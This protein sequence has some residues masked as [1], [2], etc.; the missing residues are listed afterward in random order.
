MLKNSRAVGTIDVSRLAAA[1]RGPGIDSR[2]WVSLAIV[3]A[4]K[5]D[6]DE[7]VFVDVTL[8]PSRRPEVARVGQEYAGPGFGLHTPLQVD[9]EVLV[10]APDG[11]PDNGLVVTR[12][13]HSASDPPS[14]EAVDNPQDVVLVVKEGQSVRIITSGG[15][16]VILEGRGGG[17]LVL[18]G[19]EDASARSA[20]EGDTVSTEG[21]GPF[22]SLQALL[23][24]RYQLRPSPP[25]LVIP[26]GQTIGR[27]SS[28]SDKVKTG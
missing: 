13:L 2:T 4:V 20:R 1:V 9:D 26:A 28:G 24:T 5:M 8:M 21:L 16:S 15:G 14:Q 27:I 18:L 25:P 17:S 11:D 3:N 10:T 23:D 6:S 12:R 22:S 19:G 7:G